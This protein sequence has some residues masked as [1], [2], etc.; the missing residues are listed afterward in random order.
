MSITLYSTTTCPYCKMEKDFLKSKNVAF[1]E[2]LVD[3]DEKAAEDMIKLTGQYGVPVTV[4]EKDGAKDI[5]VGWDKRK[6]A[7]LVG[8]G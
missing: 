3:Q 1:K 2:I 4:I 6:I 8:I 5:V 7:E